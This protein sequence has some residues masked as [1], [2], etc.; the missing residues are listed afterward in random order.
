MNEEERQKKERD[1]IRAVGVVFGGTDGE[2]VLDWLGHTCNLRVP[3]FGRG[4]TNE[5]AA[6][7]DGRRS[8]VLEILEAL[9]RSRLNDAAQKP[10]AHKSAP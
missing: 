1:L 6:F 5:E 3:V 2:L 8:V 4:L 7:R 9:D 10:T